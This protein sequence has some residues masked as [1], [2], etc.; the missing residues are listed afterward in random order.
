MYAT[1]SKDLPRKNYKVFNS[2][3]TLLLTVGFI[4]AKAQTNTEVFLLD[5]AVVD[6][7]IS[8]SVPKNI[9]NNNGYD[10]QPSFYNDSLVL[11]ASTRNEQTDIVSYA[12][13]KDRILWIS[14]TPNGSEYSPLKVPGKKRVSAIRLDTDGTQRLY[15]YD[16]ESGKSELLLK[17]LKVGYHVW[18]TKDIV[19]SS[20]LLENRMDLFVSDIKN[21]SDY[22]FY[23]NVGRSFHKIPNSKRVSFIDKQASIPALMSLDPLSGDVEKIIELPE[24]V[25]DVCWMINGTI[26][27]GQKNHILKFTPGTDTQWQMVAE[28]SPTIL[29]NITR[30]ATNSTSTKLALVAEVK[31]TN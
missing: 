24:E 23:K 16:I 6:N 30:L 19:V 4:T 8:L 27:A 31:T 25:Q 26:L 29:T 17:D 7:A 15:S 13:N 11:F 21:H 5:L 28:I 9:S 14:D 2:F 20:V 10:N 22:K 3:L 1:Y 18:F 12:I